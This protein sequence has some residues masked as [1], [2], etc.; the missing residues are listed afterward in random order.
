MSSV[1]LKIRCQIEEFPSLAGFVLASFKNDRKDFESFSPDFN[2]TFLQDTIQKVNAL[3]SIINPKQ[4]TAEL[5]AITASIYATQAALHQP[6]NYLEAYVNR[7]SGLT[8][9]PSDFGFKNVRKA[10]NAGN[11]QALTSS[12]D[13]VISNTKKNSAALYSKGFTPAQLANLE[14]LNHKLYTQNIAQNQKINERK[15]LVAS[16]NTQMNEL[17]NIIIDILDIGKRIYKTS[18]P[19]KLPNYTLRR[20]IARMRNQ[21]SKSIA[22]IHPVSQISESKN[23]KIAVIPQQSLSGKSPNLP[24]HNS[25]YTIHSTQFS[26][27]SSLQ[28]SNLQPTPS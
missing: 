2:A 10:N 17:W 8:I 9:D 26:T 1:R 25:S 16:N 20:L 24:A 18:N 19:A 11:I 12:L 23:T 7:A 28:N 3:T 4:L 13:L 21:S 6:L 22:T 27:A 14:A 15:S 5:K